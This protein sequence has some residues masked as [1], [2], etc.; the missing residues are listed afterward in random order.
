MSFATI[1]ELR[2]SL[3]KP[4]KD[5]AYDAKMMHEIPRTTVV[6][7]AVYLLQKAAGKKVLEFGASG[8]MHDA[9]IKAAKEVVGVDLTPGPGIIVFDL[10]RIEYPDPA[11]WATIGFER[12]FVFGGFKPEVIICGE[13][14]EH[15]ANPGW[16]LQRIKQQFPGVPMVITVPNALSTIALKHVK[17]GV[18]N[19]NQDH[20]AYYSWKTMSVL[21]ARYGFTVKEFYYYNGEPFTAEG[22]IF[23]VE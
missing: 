10:D 20:V 5:A 3:G 23:A 22:L 21:L 7:R 1:A 18:E 2:G 11:T 12:P 4:A 9:I 15:L 14:M 6:N 19:V 16:F 13:V 17:Q 8:P